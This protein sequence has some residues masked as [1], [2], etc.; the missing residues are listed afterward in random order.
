MYQ[1]PLETSTPECFECSGGRS[2][3]GNPVLQHLSASLRC[4]LPAPSGKKV[5]TGGDDTFF[6]CHSQKIVGMA[7]GVGG[8]ADVG[9]DAGKYAR[10]LIS[11]NQ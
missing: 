4:L 11:H 9:V 3:V 5:K 7:D 8:W 1:Y 2:R 6:I 10:K